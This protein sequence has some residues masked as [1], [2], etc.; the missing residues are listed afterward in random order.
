MYVRVGV[1][2]TDW[3]RW[4]AGAVYVEDKCRMLVL[5]T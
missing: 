3:W 4:Y 1:I 2:Y 5:C